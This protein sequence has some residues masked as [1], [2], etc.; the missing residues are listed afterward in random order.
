MEKLLE[1]LGA[2]LEK[3]EQHVPNLQSLKDF[4]LVEEARAKHKTA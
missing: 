2:R 4:P 3:M 1:S